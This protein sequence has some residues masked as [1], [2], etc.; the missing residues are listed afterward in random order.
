MLK[1]TKRNGIFFSK[2]EDYTNDDS[3]ILLF[4]T[5]EFK[6]LCNFVRKI[7]EHTK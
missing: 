3:V 6:K 2:I 7:S 5:C 4:Y 1:E